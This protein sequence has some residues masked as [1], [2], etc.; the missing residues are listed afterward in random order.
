MRSRCCETLFIVKIEF[1]LMTCRDSNSPGCDGIDG[2][3]DQDRIEYFLPWP[4]LFRF[5]GTTRQKNAR[6]RQRMSN[7]GEVWLASGEGAIAFNSLRSVKTPCQRTGSFL[8]SIGSE[9]SE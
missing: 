3:F 1:A 6:P 7:H 8:V 9:R 2:S 5:A 4:K